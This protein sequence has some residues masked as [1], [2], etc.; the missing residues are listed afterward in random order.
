MKG[1]PKQ[2]GFTLAETLIALILVSTVLLPASYWL[3]RSRASRS[4]VERFHALQALEARMNRAELL[5][6]DKDLGATLWDPEYMQL[7]IRMVTEGPET[8]LLGSIQ[9]R[10]GKTLVRL[11]AACFRSDSP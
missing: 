2:G 6:L 11:Q 9:N 5:C 1:K 3:Y 8:Q 7:R 10:K 4:A